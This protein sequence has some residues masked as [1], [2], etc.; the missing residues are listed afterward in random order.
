GNM[1]GLDP[2]Q[3]GE[4]AVRYGSGDMILTGVSDGDWLCVYGADFGDKG[5]SEFT[6][7]VRR[8]QDATDTDSI[9][10]IRVT[11]DKLFG[12]EPF[13]DIPLE[14]I[15]NSG[16]D[17]FVTITVP[18]EAAVTG[19]HDIYMIFAGEGYEVKSWSFD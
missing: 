16:S 17:E 18:V 3:Y 19:V 8:S 13:A 7:E 2:V 4:D 12:S 5:P 9:C 11:Q 1:A 15:M 14:S 6:I 10:A